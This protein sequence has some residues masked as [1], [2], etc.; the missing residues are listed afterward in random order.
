MSQME[1]TAREANSENNNYLIYPRPQLIMV[2]KIKRDI[3]VRTGSLTPFPVTQAAMRDG[4]SPGSR[5]PL[6]GS[7]HEPRSGSSDWQ[8]PVKPPRGT[9]FWHRGGHLPG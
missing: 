9:P 8:L 4:R 6:P 1:H 7:T 3:P 2:S 5:A